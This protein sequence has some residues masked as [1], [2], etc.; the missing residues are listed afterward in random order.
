M[1]VFIDDSGDPGFKIEKGSSKFFVISMVIFDDDLEAEKTAVKIKELKRELKFSDDVEFKFCNSRK[2]V[3]ERFLTVI[4]SSNFRVR[5]LI[6]DKEKIYSEELKNNRKS[7]YG[8]FIKTALEHSSKTIKNARIKI[9][10]SGDRIFRKS[11]L[12]YLK[13]E[14]TDKKIMNNCKLMDSKK[15]V[16]IQ[17][18]DMV[19]GAT[20]RSCEK[21]DISCRNVIKKHIENEWEFK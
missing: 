1:L 12:S 4:S 7:F 20:R 21:K 10:G 19:A 2:E 11:F 5:S 18:V 9:D 13:R 3:R 6:V 14:L 17:M 16:L 8:Y 15:N